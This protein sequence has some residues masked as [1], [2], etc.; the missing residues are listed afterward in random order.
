MTKTIIHDIIYFPVNSLNY[1][2]KN[3]LA[4]GYLGGRVIKLFTHQTCQL[5]TKISSCFLRTQ[6][7]NVLTGSSTNKP[8][9][10]KPIKKLEK[11]PVEIDQI[12]KKKEKKEKNKIEA[13]KENKN[14]LSLKSPK[15]DESKP[16]TIKNPFET[17]STKDIIVNLIPQ[18]IADEKV[19]NVFFKF[20]EEVDFQKAVVNKIISQTKQL[21][22]IT[23]KPIITLEEYK[24]VNGPKTVAFLNQ[25]HARG[26]EFSEAM[27]DVTPVESNTKLPMGWIFLHYT[28]DTS[29]NTKPMGI[30]AELTTIT[31]ENIFAKRT[32]I[33][34][35]TKDGE[36]V[37][38]SRLNEDQLESIQ[39]LFKDALQYYKYKSL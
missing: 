3:I 26:R 29:Y 35:G 9:K 38:P 16:K 1:L 25:S 21:S 10:L 37:E 14:E 13:E 24:R 19:L 8:R 27:H 7:V 34:V 17:D 31:D 12:Q 30:A 4:I 36:I 39:E 2:L 33:F 6:K 28:K 11:L 22:S 32:Y 20:L 23:I 15:K 5:I 18:P